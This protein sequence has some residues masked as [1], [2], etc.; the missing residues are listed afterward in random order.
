MSM[1]QFEVEMASAG[2]NEEQIAE[3]KAKI[4]EW[5]QT[6]AQALEE[7]IAKFREFMASIW[8]GVKETTAE[9]AEKLEELNGWFEEQNKAKP[10]VH[11][12]S[13][14][15]PYDNA[16]YNQYTRKMAMDK[17]ADIKP[18]VIHKY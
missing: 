8:E 2:Y 6:L 5:A 12:V 4:Q 1:E 17:R 14:N 3:V 13:Y 16:W 15:P 18:F 11:Y 10:E 7:V 9:L